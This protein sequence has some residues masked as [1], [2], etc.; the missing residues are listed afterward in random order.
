MITALILTSAV[1]AQAP[2]GKITYEEVAGSKDTIVYNRQYSEWWF[3]ASAGTNL[4]VY[5]SKFK[6]PIN[7]LRPI[8]STNQLVDFPAGKGYGYFTGLTGEWLPSEKRFGA[9]IRVN[10]FDYRAAT[11][12]T[13][14][15]NL[16][17]VNLVY[18]QLT[19]ISY[20]SIS[21]YARYNFSIEGL[22]AF[23]GLDFEL[24]YAWDTKFRHK[25]EH[26]GTILD[27]RVLQL[28]NFKFRYGLNIGAGWD[29]FVTDIAD[30]FRMN[31]TPFI[32]F[33][34]GSAIL[35]D[36]GSSWNT[37]FGRIG[38]SV[39][40]GPDEVNKDTLF[41]DPFARPDEPY[42]A[43]VDMEQPVE[44]PGF[45]PLANMPKTDLAVVN[46]GKVVEEV[47]VKPQP[48]IREDTLTASVEKPEEGKEEKKIEIV[49]GREETFSY[50][51]PEDTKPT[52][53]IEKYLDELANYM[54][55]NPGLEVRIVGYSDN[56]GTLQQN[57]SRS[58][59]RANQ[60]VRYLLNKGISRGRV[61]DYARGS[62]NPIADNRTPQGREKNR[63]VEIQVVQ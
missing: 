33:H 28:N 48:P 59:R 38:L 11:S 6:T 7:P 25:F 44:F 13:E 58:R 47:S 3:G 15:N 56:A 37:I 14:A 61:Y 55:Q 27:D 18:Q 16:D 23:A 40:I 29:I 12:E 32:S 41:F 45:L 24:P 30:K 21:T 63:R 60:V 1:A 22:H 36:F 17:T 46:T 20:I 49:P 62:L 43:S 19:K 52:P 57:Q 4:N 8:D 54:K 26:T 9:G 51:K 50:K 10:L 39:K 35:S 31:F 5:F 34:G 42:L 2:P 53:A